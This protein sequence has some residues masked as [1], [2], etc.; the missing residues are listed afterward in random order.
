LHTNMSAI[1]K[2]ESES[3]L[4]TVPAASKSTAMI[5]ATAIALFSMT[6]LEVDALTVRAA[7]HHV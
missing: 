6:E 3:N 2:S 1:P 7:D 4:S 5:Q